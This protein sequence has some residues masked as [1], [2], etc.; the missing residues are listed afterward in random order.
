VCNTGNVELVRSLGA[1]EVID[2]LQEDFTKNGQTYDAII[3]AVG[4]YSFRRGRRAL[5]RGGLYIATDLGRLLVET[6]ALV[7]ATRWVG[8]KRVKFP[9]GRKNKQDLVFMKGLIEAGTYRAVI[10]RRYPLEQVVEAHRYVETWQKTGN[11][12]L[13]VGDDRRTQVP[14]PATSQN[15]RW[16]WPPGASRFNSSGDPSA[17]SLPRSRTPI[18]WSPRL[19]LGKAH[20]EVNQVGRVERLR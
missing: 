5:K 16:T 8:D 17:T 10:D 7:V 14:S 12:V 19:R 1:D 2:Y 6:V 20:E 13:T 9:G 15:E 18:R 4:K 3:D 11:V